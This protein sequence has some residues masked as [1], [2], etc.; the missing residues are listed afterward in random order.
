MSWFDVKVWLSLSTGLHMDALHV[1]FGLLGQVAVALAL[2]RGLASP[3]PWL[4]L[5]AGVTANEYY[6]LAYETW[7]N[8]DDQ[9]AETVKDVWNTML[10]P[11]LLMLAARFAPGL[12]VRS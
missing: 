3:W 6:D 4:A 2:R 8:R 1:Y 7:P 9:Y 10:A 12:F 11:T 5:L